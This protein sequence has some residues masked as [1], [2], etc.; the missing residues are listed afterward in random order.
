MPEYFAI[1]STLSEGGLPH[2]KY[3][4]VQSGP[5][6]TDMVTVPTFNLMVNWSAEEVKDVLSEMNLNLRYLRLIP[7]GLTPC[8]PL[9]KE[10]KIIFEISLL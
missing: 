1:Q 5:R 3:F 2:A 7:V 10:R 4:V 9:Y 6:E 8:D